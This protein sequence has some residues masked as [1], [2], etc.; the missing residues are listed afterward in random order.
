MKYKEFR[1]ISLLST[2]NFEKIN[3]FTRRDGFETAIPLLKVSNTLLTLM[4]GIESQIGRWIRRG[5]IT[6]L[7]LSGKIKKIAI[8]SNHIPEELIDFA[9]AVDGKWSVDLIGVQ[10]EPRRMNAKNIAAYDLIITIGRTVQACFAMGTPVYVYDRF[11]GPGY[12]SKDNFKQ[13]KE[14]NFS[15]RGFSRRSCKELMQDIEDGYALNSLRLEKLHDIAKELFNHEHKFEA[16]YK[17]LLQI[18]SQR[19]AFTVY[20]NLMKE[21]MKIYTDLLIYGLGDE[22]HFSQLYIDSGTGFFEDNS[23]KW[24]ASDTYF[25][26]K[27]CKIEGSVK[28]LRFDPCCSACKCTITEFSI[29]GKEM[30]DKMLPINY[31]VSDENGEEFL[32]EDPQYLLELS[33]FQSTSLEIRIVY[34]F[35]TKTDKEVREGFQNELDKK[36]KEL[37]ESNKRYNDLA[38]KID[39]R[40]GKFYR[41]YKLFRH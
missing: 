32:T 38:E 36:A 9:Q 1:H 6:I 7:S 5:R 14:N 30:K 24:N 25:V 15:G 11:G 35:L 17:A 33:E 40:F 2:K 3:S 4:A 8:I 10:Y 13:A 19:R 26:E 23:L 39:R 12:I 28:K 22:T 16:M 18:P 34:K 29:N 20:D 41:L 31:I 21:R 37:E 27:I